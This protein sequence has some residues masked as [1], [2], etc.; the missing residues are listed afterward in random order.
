MGDA[1]PLKIRNVF[2][3]DQNWVGEYPTAY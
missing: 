1:L 2:S 3:E